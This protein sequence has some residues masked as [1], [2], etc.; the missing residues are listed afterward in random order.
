[1]NYIQ[2]SNKVVPAKQWYEEGHGLVAPHR[3]RY[4]DKEFNRRK[5][6]REVKLDFRKIT[7]SLDRYSVK[8]NNCLIAIDF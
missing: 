4:F 6:R 7:K 5:E 8:S 3:F 2:F 1:M